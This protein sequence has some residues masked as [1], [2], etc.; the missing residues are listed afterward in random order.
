MFLARAAARSIS[1]L[2]A[3][4]AIASVPASVLRSSRDSTREHSNRVRFTRDVEVKEFARVENIK[5]GQ[6]YRHRRGCKFSGCKLD[7]H[8]CQCLRKQTYNGGMKATFVTFDSQIC[9]ELPYSES[10]RRTHQAQFKAN[11]LYDDRALNIM[12]WNN[13]MQGQSFSCLP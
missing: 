2:F 10:D 3:T 13:S 1:T 9:T 5:C 8:H 6:G 12:E 4:P 7:Y 11:D